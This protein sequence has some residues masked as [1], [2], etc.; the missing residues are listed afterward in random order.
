M[1]ASLPVRIA[2]LGSGVHTLRLTPDAAAL[3]LDPSEFRDLDVAVRLDMGAGQIVATV[4][5]SATANLVC[6]R[7]A[8]P[9]D[10][11]VQ[12][13]YTV[14][15]TQNAEMAAEGD[16]DVRRYGAYDASLDLGD[17]VHD[18]LLLALPHRR[19]APGAEA[20]DVPLRFGADA[21]DDAPADDRWEALRRLRDD[22]SLN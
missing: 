12:G 8:Q 9:F 5:A 21:S 16:E 10:Q 20:L 4:E 17:V 22:G 1:T 2:S 19:L 18:T 3:G 13:A 14:L 15:F 7:T 11:R 6:D